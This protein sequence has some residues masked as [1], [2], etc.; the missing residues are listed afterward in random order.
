MASVV[1]IWL[2]VDFWI[3]RS[4]SP[5]LQTIREAEGFI[6]VWVSLT[7]MTWTRRGV[8]G[9]LVGGAVAGLASLVGCRSG[10]KPKDPRMAVLTR[11]PKDPSHDY[12]S[13][14][15]KDLESTPTV[16]Q[17]VHVL[18][19]A[20]KDRTVRSDIFMKALPFIQQFFARYQIKMN[21][22]PTSD[23]FEQERS[24]PRHFLI[25]YDT[26]NENVRRTM[27]AQLEDY[28]SEHSTWERHVLL[29]DS[30]EHIVFNSP[31]EALPYFMEK[32]KPLYKA[33]RTWNKPTYQWVF[34]QS[35]SDELR[36]YADLEARDQGQD[37]S[38]R[39]MARLLSRELGNMMGLPE[40]DDPCYERDFPK[41]VGGVPN[42]M[43]LDDSAHDLAGVVQHYD[44]AQ[45]FGCAL[46]QLQVG[47]VHN[48]L[49]RGQIFLQKITRNETYES[50]LLMRNQV[51]CR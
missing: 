35:L 49:M 37:I 40:I 3:Q 15:Y 31:E 4:Q 42:L 12:N 36:M 30:E 43:V 26:I 27:K 6:K 29:E 19:H 39:Y 33:L 11:P 10:P 16:P 8:L 20:G 23:L 47:M 50:T 38:A 41:L 32:A 34:M 13:L 5:H 1:V 2:F 17:E 51:L 21:F 45:P 9:A 28:F 48:Y 18:F 46:N 24:N 22:V 25:T 7:L 44:Q 14:L